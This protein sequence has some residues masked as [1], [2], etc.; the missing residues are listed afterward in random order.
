MS[1]LPFLCWE[2]AEVFMT[3]DSGYAQR[4]SGGLLGRHWHGRRGVIVLPFDTGPYFR[5]MAYI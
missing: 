1:H 2:W 4:A 3:G 5:F